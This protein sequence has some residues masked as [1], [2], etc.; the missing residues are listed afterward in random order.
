MHTHTY[1]CAYT[2]T[3]THYTLKYHTRRHKT[4]L[5]ALTF[6]YSLVVVFVPAQL[7]TLPV[8]SYILELHTK[9]MTLPLVEL[10]FC[11]EIVGSRFIFVVDAEGNWG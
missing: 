10:F 1:E 6:S 4:I 3:C 5:Q 9:G 7:D 11:W 8:A 2:H